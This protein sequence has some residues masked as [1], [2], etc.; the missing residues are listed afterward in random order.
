MFK[1][2]QGLRER[3]PHPRRP[4]RTRS[5]GPDDWLHPSRSGKEPS[6]GPLVSDL[7]RV[8]RTQ[9]REA[10]PY[11]PFAA[12]HRALSRLL[13]LDE[14]HDVLAAAH[15]GRRLGHRRVDVELAVR[16]VDADRVEVAHVGAAETGVLCPEAAVVVR[17]ADELGASHLAR[18]C[19]GRT[20][21]RG[22]SERS[23]SAAARPPD[24]A[25]LRSG[26]MQAAHGDAR[27]AGTPRLRG[28]C[29]WRRQRRGRPRSRAPR[30]GPPR[31][32]GRRCRRLRGT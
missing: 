25:R 20:L 30:A 27:H 12:V 32:S 28:A 31:A 19:R 6:L 21:R 11:A 16:A 10:S 15:L 13:R 5:D 23:E 3:R 8:L 22:Q 18:N 2:D 24:M 1:L 29:S 26:A 17:A 7:G 4:S 14:E 9:T